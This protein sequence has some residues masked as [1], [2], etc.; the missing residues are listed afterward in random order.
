M[1]G[2]ARAAGE[3]SASSAQNKAS[4]HAWPL[5]IVVNDGL[6]RLKKVLETCNRNNYQGKQVHAGRRAADFIFSSPLIDQQSAP[7]EA[8]IDG[9]HNGRI[10]LR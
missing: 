3:A 5:A 4:S 1:H 8:E 7:S 6:C 9:R 10:W 2:H